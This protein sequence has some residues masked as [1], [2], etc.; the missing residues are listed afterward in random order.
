MTTSILVIGATGRTGQQLI[1][2][3]NEHPDHPQVHAFAR[4]PQSFPSEIAEK[5]TSVQ[6]GDA[7]VADQVYDA[8]VATKATHIVIA[9]GVPNSTAP[10]T[11]RGDSA[12][13]I[14][15]AMKRYPK[16][17]KTVIISALG[18]SDTKIQF[19]FGVGMVIY[20][21]LRHLLKDHDRQEA[22]F[23]DYYNDNEKGLLIVRPTGLVD[24]QEGSKVLLFDGQGRTPSLTVDRYDMAAWVVNQIANDGDCFGK[25]INISKAV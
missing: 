15:E 2:A 10:S 11:L 20:Y 13:A 22:S 4:N 21:I 1:K 3:A 19:G 24:G 8:L 16:P 23:L 5:C 6:K 18:A 17:V 9:I 12:E 7:L 25:A 14:I